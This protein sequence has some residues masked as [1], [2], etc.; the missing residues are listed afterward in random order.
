MD[1]VVALVKLLPS[2]E[3]V[4]ELRTHVSSNI[5]RFSKDNTRFT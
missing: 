5:A 3:E 4:A 1:E 2:K